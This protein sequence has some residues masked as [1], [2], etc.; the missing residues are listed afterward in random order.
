MAEI[1]GAS[2]ANRKMYFRLTTLD[3]SPC[4]IYIHI[5]ISVSA[6]RRPTDGR[7]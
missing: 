7:F 5:Y 2:L 4:Y 3:T 6:Y 1:R